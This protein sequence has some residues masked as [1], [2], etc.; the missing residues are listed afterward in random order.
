MLTYGRMEG[1]GTTVIQVKSI[2]GNH[3]AVAVVV[4]I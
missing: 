3:S 2:V 4:K 1:I